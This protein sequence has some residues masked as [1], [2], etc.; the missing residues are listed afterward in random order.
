MFQTKEGSINAFDEF[1]NMSSLTLT[2]ITWNWFEPII[3]NIQDMPTLKEKFMKRAQFLETNIVRAIYILVNMKCNHTKHDI[4]QFA[5]EL[6]VLGKMMGISD[7]Q[8]L[9]Y[10]KRNFHQGLKLTC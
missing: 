7:E 8:E 5:H 6:K 1:K 4:E 10:L 2:D 9:E 3:N